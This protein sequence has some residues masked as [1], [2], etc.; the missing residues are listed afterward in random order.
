MDHVGGNLALKA[1]YGAMV[2]GPAAD[3]ERIPGI[4]VALADGDVFQVRRLAMA[5]EVDPQHTP[6]DSHT[7]RGGVGWDA[8]QMGSQELR[9]LDTPGHTRGHIVFYLPHSDAVFVGDTLFAVGCG[10]LFEGTPAQM[11]HRFSQSPHRQLGFGRPPALIEVC[12]GWARYPLAARKS[13]PHICSQSKRPD[14]WRVSTVP[15]AWPSSSSCPAPPKCTARMST[16]Q[17]TCGARWGDAKSS[18]G[19]AKSSLGDAESSLG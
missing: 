13:C 17:P 5:A 10:R 14:V 19:D 12:A 6:L 4:D 7:T 11:F 18:L 8:A 16:R 3:K 9:V 2:V 1:K 15:T